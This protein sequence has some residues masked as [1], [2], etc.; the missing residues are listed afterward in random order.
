[1]HDLH[2]VVRVQVG[3]SVVLETCGGMADE[4]AGLANTVETLFQIA[5]ISKQFTAAAILLLADRGTLSVHDEMGRWIGGCP[6]AWRPIT[7]HHLL[8]HTAGLGHWKD[9]PD[10][11]LRGRLEPADE[12]AIFQRAPLRNEPGTQWYYSSPGYVLLGHI[13]AQAS[14]RS[15]AEFLADQ[16]F[17]PLGMAAT[18]AG[19][20]D[21]R[22]ELATGYSGGRP[23]PSFDLTTA[24][25][26]A[27]DVWSTTGDL[28]KWNAAVARRML[29]SDASWQAMLAAQ[30][31]VE[32][33]PGDAGELVTDGYGYAW[34]TGSLAG[35][36]VLYHP[37]DNPGYA[38]VI[39]WLPGEDIRL[40]L[41]T[42]ED[43]SS[44]QE[45]AIA[46]LGAAFA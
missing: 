30:W 11:D 5:S 22:P 20:G 37:G 6:A 1:M 45:L 29:L 19:N 39:A 18:F 46:A 2:G 23:V 10:L 32:D 27:G 44:I 16:V 12:L 43:T 21:G 24:S 13:V 14:G 31:P 9:F 34:F 41:L 42:N 38:A 4:Q 40:V 7:I 15:Y 3:D 28:A 25:L 8:V 17:A 36:R 26:G 33:P 35:L